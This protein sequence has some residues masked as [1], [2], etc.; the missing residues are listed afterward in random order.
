[1]TWV[2]PL[3]S[4]EGMDLMLKKLFGVVAV[5]TV[6]LVATV[7]TASAQAYP[8]AANEIRA[9]G[10]SALR[11]TPG[12]AAAFEAECFLPGSTVTFTLAGEG[13]GT[14][15]ADADGVAT[16]N[17]TVPAATPLGSADVIATGTGC[18]S[19]ALT[20]VLS[21]TISAAAQAPTDPLP[22]TGSSSTL[23]MTQI[24]LAAIVAGGFLVILTNRRRELAPVSGSTRT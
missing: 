16:I 11:Y 4:P 17:T 7:S 13:L 8:P 6:A 12:G 10:N 19:E 22:R 3:A 15:T 20:L 9:L 5:T 23:P 14:A 1:M 18:D 24:A 21:V 2:T